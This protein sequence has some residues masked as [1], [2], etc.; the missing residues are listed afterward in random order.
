[1]DLEGMTGMIALARSRG[2]RV[3]AGVEPRLVRIQKRLEAAPDLP[4]RKW[5]ERA[6]GDGDSSLSHVPH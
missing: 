3:E 2:F 6:G 5:N 1:M 4:C